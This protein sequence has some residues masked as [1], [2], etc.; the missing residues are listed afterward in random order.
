MA[1]CTKST[2]AILIA[3]SQKEHSANIAGRESTVTFTG[4]INWLNDQKGDSTPIKNDVINRLIET[5]D[6]EN[7]YVE[8]LDEDQNILIIPLNENFVSNNNVECEPVNYLW[9]I[10]DEDGKIKRG[11]ILQYIPSDKQSYP[12]LP[13][14][15]FYNYFHD[16]ELASD[17]T[18]A[19]LSIGDIYQYEF[20]VVDNLV[21]SGTAMNG[22]YNVDEGCIHYVLVHWVIYADGHI[23]ADWIE[24]LGCLS[25]PPNQL[26]DELETIGPHGTIQVPVE[27]TKIT[28]RWVVGVGMM[29]SYRIWSNETLKAIVNPGVPS[30]FSGVEHHISWVENYSQSPNPPTPLT[31][32]HETGANCSLANQN[33]VALCDVDGYVTYWDGTQRMFTKSK[34]WI[35]Y[36]EFP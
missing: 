13:V 34:G 15:T 24:D 20:T 33:Y 36:K 8:I 21:S 25:C 7:S 14:N 18:Y 5:M 4:I 22:T 28:D 2:E 10:E 35:S 30:V 23:E 32:W 17:G 19:F 1:G 6:Y 12:S 11:N 16:G 29:N 3:S 9:F 26:C 27:K 31:V